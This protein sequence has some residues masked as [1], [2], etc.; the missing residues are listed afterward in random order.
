MAIVE[1]TNMDES[2]YN[3]IDLQYRHLVVNLD[4]PVVKKEAL[5]TT[6][7]PKRHQESNSS[8]DTISEYAAPVADFIDTGRIVVPRQNGKMV[9]TEVVKQLS[10]GIKKAC[11][12]R[13]IADIRYCGLYPQEDMQ[14]QWGQ[15][16]DP[17]RFVVS[18]IRVGG[19]VS[20]PKFRENQLLPTLPTL[21]MRLR[22]SMGTTVKEVFVEAFYTNKR[23]TNRNPV[24]EISPLDIDEYVEAC[25]ISLSKYEVDAIGKDFFRSFREGYLAS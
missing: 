2:I 25:P 17:S 15:W 1:G 6:I 4:N 20:N 12:P 21:F 13:M 22:I 16:W 7:K 11:I 9:K 14:N 10:D 18:G 5:S 3:G 24:I 19:L 23:D 8:L